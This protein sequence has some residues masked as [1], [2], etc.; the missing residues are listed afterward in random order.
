MKKNVLHISIFWVLDS[1]F[2]KYVTFVK[3]IIWRKKS[4]KL[5][6]FCISAFF[7]VLDSDFFKYVNF[8]KMIIW[9]KNSRK[10]IHIFKA[11][12][13]N[14]SISRIRIWIFRIRIRIFFA[15]GSTRALPSATLPAEVRRYT[16]RTERETL[17][18]TILSVPK[19]TANLYCICLSID[20]P[21]T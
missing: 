15:C 4:R 17:C 20:L 1:D 3:I 21:F 19:F 13:E 16:V 11:Y 8:V 18:D 10:L 9:K 7:G 12:E 6:T 2:Y 5:K 14:P